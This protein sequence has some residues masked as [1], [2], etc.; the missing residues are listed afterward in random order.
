MAAKEGRRPSG[1]L[2]GQTTKI[3]ALTYVLGRPV[4]LKLSGGDTVD[5]RIAD[6]S[7]VRCG[8]VKCLIADRSHDAN[9]CAR[10]SAQP[11]ACRSSPGYR[12]RKTP[13]GHDRRRYRNR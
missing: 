1:A 11:D 6:A 2:G 4:A 7:L 10:P 8:P 3:H 5:I 9:A 13:T 12:N